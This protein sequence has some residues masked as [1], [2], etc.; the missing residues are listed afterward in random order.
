MEVVAAAACGVF[1]VH[2]NY[3]TNQNALRSPVVQDVVYVY[4]PYAWI[5][6]HLLLYGSF[7]ACAFSRPD[8]RLL[9]RRLVLGYTMKAVVQFVTIVPQPRLLGGAAV[10]RDVPVWSMQG[11]ADMM[12][13]GHTMCTMLVLYKY[14]YRSIVVFAMMFQLVFAKMHYMSDVLMAIL[15]STAIETWTI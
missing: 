4:S 15:A 6:V 9:T 13:S 3:W 2:M 8:L 11:C 5:L 7:V 14:K 1:Y 10:C 12:F